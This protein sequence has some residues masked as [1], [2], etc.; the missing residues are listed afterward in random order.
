MVWNITLNP[1]SI[2]LQRRTLVPAVLSCFF[3]IPVVEI[4]CKS[5]IYRYIDLYKSLGVERNNEFVQDEV[6]EA[7]QKIVSK[8]NKNFQAYSQISKITLLKEPLEMT[9]SQKVKRN[10]VAKTY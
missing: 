4:T 7:V 6:L 10:F 8:V 9:T 2:S 1:G 3:M 5:T